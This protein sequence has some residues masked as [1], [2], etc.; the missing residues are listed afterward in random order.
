MIPQNLLPFFFWLLICFKSPRGRFEWFLSPNPP[1]FHPR[2]VGGPLAP[3]SP[4]KRVPGPPS[5]PPSPAAPPKPKPSFAPAP[6]CPGP[7]FRSR[8]NMEINA[9]LSVLRSFWGG[10]T[11]RRP[12]LS[13]PLLTRRRIG[14]FPWGFPVPPPLFAPPPVPPG[15]TPGIASSGVIVDSWTPGGQMIRR[16]LMLDPKRVFKGEVQWNPP[17]F[18]NSP[19]FFKKILFS[20]FKLKTIN[21]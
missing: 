18:K 1:N 16:F 11:P 19:F 21:F 20:H 2:G 9:P 17:T 14:F 3:P 15:E 7:P 4:L 5:S 8:E 13:P 6:L 12:F 10:R